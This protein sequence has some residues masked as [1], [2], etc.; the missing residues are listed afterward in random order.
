VKL[1]AVD[2]STR[3]ASVALVEDEQILA[4]V[5]DESGEHSDRI[6]AVIDEVLESAGARLADLDALAIGA[7]PGSFT[8]LRIGMATIK[9]LAFAADKPLW[10]VSSLAAVAALVTIPEGIDRIAVV[11][12]ARRKEIFLGVYQAD[13]LSPCGE[14]RVLKPSTLT[15]TLAELGCDSSSTLLIGEGL[16]LYPEAAG[17]FA[18]AEGALPYPTALGVAKVALASSRTDVRS[19]ATPVYIRPSEAEIRFPNGNPG[20]TFA[21]RPKKSPT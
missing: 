7:G 17:G 8:G 16:G 1:L 4:E 20:G 2:T 10:A 18:I 9:G 5:R 21:P 19:L 15:E 11:L 13:G 3:A 6:I 12:D 14:E